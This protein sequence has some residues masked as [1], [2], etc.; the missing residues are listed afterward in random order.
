MNKIILSLMLSTL[1][2]TSDLSL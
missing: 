2:N 1:L